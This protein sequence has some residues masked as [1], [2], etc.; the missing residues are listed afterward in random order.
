MCTRG[1]SQQRE[2]AIYWT[3]EN[4]YKSCINNNIKNSNN[5]QKTWIRH[6]SRWHTNGQQAYVKMLIPRL[7]GKCKWKPQWEITS[8]PLG[9]LLSKT[10]KTVLVR[11]FKKWNLVQFGGNVKLLWAMKNKMTIPLKI[12]NEWPLLLLFSL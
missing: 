2:G 7:L 12:K 5:A 11:G 9:W 1:H 4:I 3:R 6:F 8:H 10:W